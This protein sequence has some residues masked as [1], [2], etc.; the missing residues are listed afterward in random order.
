MAKNNEKSLYIITLLIIILSTVTSAVG[1]LYKT[2]GKA[3]NFVNQ[4]GNTVKM[5]GNGLYARDSLFKAATARGTDFTILCVAIPMLIIALILDA[6]K[7]TLKNRLFLT[8]IISVFMYYSASIAFGITYNILDLVYI[9]LF[10]SSLFGLIVSITS[11]HMKDILIVKSLPYKGI[12]IF[13]AL[14][15]AALIAAWLPDI[16]TS[17]IA[18]SS[19]SLIEVYTT[20]ITYVLDI[21]ILAPLMFICLFQLKNR[22]GL[23]YVLLESLLMLCMIVGMM[24]PIQTVFEL[25]AGIKL[26]IGEIVTKGLSFIILALFALYFNIKLFENIKKG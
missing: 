8:G 10:S 13:L 15:G 22:N 17:L 26:S 19:L 3:F 2:S 4:Y 18:K 16:I 7:K 23:G 14:S 9:A 6:K 1:L 25:S 21:G 12:Y 11:I 24:I 20:E 5:Y